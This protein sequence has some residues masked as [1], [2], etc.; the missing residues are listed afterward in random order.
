MF[1]SKEEKNHWILTKFADSASAYERSIRDQTKP[2]VI[3]KNEEKKENEKTTILFV[4][5]LFQN[6]YLKKMKFFP[7]SP[8]QLWR[9]E[10]KIFYKYFER[11][12]ACLSFL[13]E[14]TSP[15]V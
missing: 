10:S 4:L 2:I 5:C 3:R 9:L 8:N 11:I 1:C 13:F 12:Q 7:F 6:E 15:D 14:N